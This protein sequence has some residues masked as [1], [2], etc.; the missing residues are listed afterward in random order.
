MSTCP[1]KDLLSAY[2]DGELAFPWKGMIEQHLQECSACKKVYSQYTIIHRSMAESANRREL[3]TAA[4]LAKLLVKRDAVLQM[5][6][7]TQKKR[8]V[9]QPGERCFYASVRIPVPA[10]A[11]AVLLFVLMPLVLFFRVE[12]TVSSVAVAQPSFAPIIP[13]SIEG[14]KSIAE[15]DYGITQ[16][17]GNQNYV[18]STKVV[19]T[20]AKFFTVSEFAR[21]YSKNENLFQPV[22]STVDLKISSSSFPLSSEYQPLYII[23]D[24]NV[25]ISNR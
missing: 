21:L 8:W 15:I 6:C 4:S 17:S 7:Q 1:N 3:D 16:T 22:Q 23:P 2:I 20:N 19:N 9:V 24:S 25:R 12:H 10:V 14:Q 5:K 18:I 13:V 11:A